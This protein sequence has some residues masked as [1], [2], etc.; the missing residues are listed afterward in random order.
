[1]GGKLVGI[2]VGIVSCMIG[3]FIGCLCAYPLGHTL[4]KPFAE[5]TINEVQFLAIV[6]RIIAEEGWKFAF[7]MRMSPVCPL[8]S[9]NYA[10][11]LTEMSFGH[12]ALS[13]LGS[14]PVIAFEVYLA[15]TAA[16]FAA[17][18]GS[19][20]QLYVSIAINVPIIILLIVMMI[21]V[22]G[23]YDTYVSESRM[24]TETKHNLKSVHTLQ[25]YTLTRKRSKRTAS[26]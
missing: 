4:L 13:C 5:K 6:N 11:T 12:Y 2:I 9:L 8:E 18:G 1:M 21:K 23:K 25:G 7:L 24:D 3:T 20:T 15:S 26:A 10:C 17:G 19:N 16:D 14:L 22:K